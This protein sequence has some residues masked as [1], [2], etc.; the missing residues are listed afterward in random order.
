MR[1]DLTLRRAALRAP[2]DVPASRRD[3]GSGR[4][5]SA[6]EIRQRPIR[7]QSPFA[8]RRRPD[9]RRHQ[10]ALACPVSVRPS[11]SSAWPYIGDESKNVAPDSSARSTTARAFCSAFDPCTSNVRHVPIPTTGTV[12]PDDPSIRVSMS[13]IDCPPYTAVKRQIHF[14]ATRA[15]RWLWPARSRRW[16]LPGPGR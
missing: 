9:L 10:R 4:D 11:T 6:P 13:A 2:S 3:C 15:R 16:R 7:L 14:T 1:R 12:S 8:G 5:R